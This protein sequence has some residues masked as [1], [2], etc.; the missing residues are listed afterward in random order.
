MRLS[1]KRTVSKTKN[2]KC[3]NISRNWEKQE[4]NGSCSEHPPS[5]YLTFTSA[6]I[7]AVTAITNTWVWNAITLIF[8][9]LSGVR[10][11]ALNFYDQ[12]NNNT[13]LSPQNACQA[14]ACLKEAAPSF[15]PEHVSSPSSG[16]IKPETCRNRRLWVL[17][18]YDVYISAVKG[19]QSSLW[20]SFE[21]LL[22]SSRVVLLLVCDSSVRGGSGGRALAAVWRLRGRGEV[23]REA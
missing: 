18:R 3:I 12:K 19:G 20:R 4:K 10:N 15:F 7:R 9:S 8:V 21:E 16:F 14:K 13:C 1:A 17:S 5:G 23:G 11:P 2:N 6:S 22:T